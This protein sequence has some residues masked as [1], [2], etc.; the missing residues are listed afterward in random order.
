MA[1]D[2]EV[3]LGWGIRGAKHAE[4]PG[5]EIKPLNRQIVN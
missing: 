4:S 5:D 2:L 1:F 3:F